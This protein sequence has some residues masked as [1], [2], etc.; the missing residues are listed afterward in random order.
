MTTTMTTTTIS[1]ST[2]CTDGSR[3][4]IIIFITAAAVVVV[5]VVEVVVV[6][7][8]RTL[9][10]YH[11]DMLVKRHHTCDNYARDS[12]SLTHDN[13]HAH[14]RRPCSTQ[15]QLQRS[16]SLVNTIVFI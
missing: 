15:Q 6:A 13:A 10:Q 2:P 12:V 7:I 1:I 8:P 3:D 11:V 5:V 14:V 4:T 9:L 16:I